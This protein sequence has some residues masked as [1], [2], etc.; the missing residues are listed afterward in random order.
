MAESKTIKPA[1]PIG[2]FTLIEL[3]VVIAILGVLAAIA[4]QQLALYRLRAF[5]AVAESDLRN[6]ATAEEARYA[7]TSNYL[8][9]NDA[10]SCEAGL[11]GYRRSN[12]VSLAMTAGTGSFTG[13]SSHINGSK[14]WSFDTTDGRLIF[15]LT[16]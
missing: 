13:T 5:D 10:A 6:A 12:G 3:L 11:Q 14:I 7:T 8:T 16:P 9:C 4:L 15:S 1:H 2:G